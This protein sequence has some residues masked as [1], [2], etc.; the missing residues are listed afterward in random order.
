MTAS[1]DW[2][3]LLVPSLHLGE[4]VL[5]G[6]AVYL[7]LFFLL[8]ILRREAGQLGISDLLVVV[9]IAD[10]AQ[11][12]MSSDYRSITEGAILVA[13]IAFWDY[14]LDWL[15]FRVTFLRRLL[16]PPPLLL[17]RNGRLQRENMKREMLQEDELMALLR[18]HGMRSAGEVKACYLEG[19]GRISVIPG[20]AKRKKT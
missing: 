7:F 18:E 6:T 5:R 9:L 17:I 11:N 1:I 14:F 3:A 8:R 4:V 16:R 15:S 19:D 13:T 20:N 12:A 2:N 10:A